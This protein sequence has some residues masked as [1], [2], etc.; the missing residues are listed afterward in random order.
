MQDTKDSS[1]SLRNPIRD[2]PSQDDHRSAG[3]SDSDGEEESLPLGH[4]FLVGALPNPNHPKPWMEAFDTATYSKEM[5][6]CFCILTAAAV[7]AA[8]QDAVSFMRPA[9][10]H[11]TWVMGN[12]LPTG[13]WSSLCL[14][15]STPA[16]GSCN[17]GLDERPVEPV[18]CSQ[19]V[20]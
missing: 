3:F 13:K 5:V 19:G 1:R 7:H 20:L 2:S 4:G 16:I 9:D 14:A 17:L 8:Y 15:V 6:S 10:S 11:M 18:K 12:K